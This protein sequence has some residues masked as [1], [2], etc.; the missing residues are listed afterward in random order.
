MTLTGNKEKYIKDNRERK[1]ENGVNTEKERKKREK[2]KLNQQN[3]EKERKKRKINKIN[4]IKLILREK[5]I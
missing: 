5:E 4:E 2:N 1:K 3:T